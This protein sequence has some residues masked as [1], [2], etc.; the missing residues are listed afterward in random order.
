MKIISP[1][2]NSTSGTT[3]P[4]NGNTGKVPP[5]KPNQQQEEF[6][7]ESFDILLH[8]IKQLLNE[9]SETIENGYP[10]KNK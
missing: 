1:I 7:D 9:I 5:Q 8:E 3:G 2:G 6:S 4:V 10:N